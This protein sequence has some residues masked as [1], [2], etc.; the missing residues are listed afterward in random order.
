MI[1]DLHVHTIYSQDSLLAPED[2][3]E[4]ALD[5][6]LDGICVTEHDSLVASRTAE[7][8]AEGTPLIVF[9]GVEA[10]TDIGHLLVYGV[11]EAQWQRYENQPGMP[12]QELVE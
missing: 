6:G 2:M 10:T 3:I 5:L 4:R 1:I 12:A 7:E 9:R 8:F 11:T